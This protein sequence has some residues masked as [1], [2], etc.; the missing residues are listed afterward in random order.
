MGRYCSDFSCIGGH[1][2]HKAVPTSV[3]KRFYAVTKYTEYPKDPEKKAAA[4]RALGVYN[5][6]TNRDE[7]RAFLEDFEN[8][9]GG[10]GKGDKSLNFALTFSKSVKTVDNTTKACN[11]D[12]LTRIANFVLC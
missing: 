8:N 5:T 7:R 11:A 1:A 2:S 4:T 12:Y 3:L 6:L 9:G 10:R